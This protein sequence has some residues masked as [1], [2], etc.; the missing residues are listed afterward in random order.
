VA[1]V[2]APSPVLPTQ[3]RAAAIIV[4]VQAI[5]LVVAALVVIVK[6]IGGGYDSAGR[7]WSD[8]LIALIG[9]AALVFSA[10]GLSYLRAVVRTPV[11]L[12]EALALPVAYSLVQAGRW[13]YGAPILLSAVAVLVLLL[14]P[15]ARAVLD[16]RPDR[17]A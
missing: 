7:A 16:R 3:V 8:A 12:I 11:L 2:S 10:R 15:A 1:D 17:P 13:I 6:I 14:T 4:L 9:A 5:G